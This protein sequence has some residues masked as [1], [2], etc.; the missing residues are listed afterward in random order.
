MCE[1]K[2]DTLVFSTVKTVELSDEVLLT[3]LVP[4][5]EATLHECFARM[6][7]V[8]RFTPK[9]VLEQKAFD[10][11]IAIPL[12]KIGSL[13][14]LAQ[15]CGFPIYTPKVVLVEIDKKLTLLDFCAAYLRVNEWGTNGFCS[16]TRKKSVLIVA[17]TSAIPN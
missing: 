1:C 16:A 15:K 17:K 5:R 9:E 13:S 11:N 14:A 12:A 10:S 4:S 8:S 2:R 6:L 7:L 3:M